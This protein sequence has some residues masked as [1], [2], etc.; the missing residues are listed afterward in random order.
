[1]PIC[2]PTEAARKPSRLAPWSTIHEMHA[3]STRFD[4]QRG[5]IGSDDQNLIVLWT[6]ASAQGTRSGAVPQSCRPASRACRRT[7]LQAS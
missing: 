7:C 1:M 2:A 3:H 5:A 6:S 4:H